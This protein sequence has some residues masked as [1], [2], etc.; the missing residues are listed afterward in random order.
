MS[1]QYIS[2]FTLSE[3]ITLCRYATVRSSTVIADH[4][5]SWLIFS[6]PAVLS[7]DREAIGKFTESDWLEIIA[8][9]HAGMTAE[10]VLKDSFCFQ[11]GC[12]GAILPRRSK[13]NMACGYKG[14]SVH[15]VPS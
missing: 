3:R 7:G 15:N 1:P 10:G 11:S 13:A 2:L 5:T 14:C 12:S 8:V 4:G 6:P 9:T